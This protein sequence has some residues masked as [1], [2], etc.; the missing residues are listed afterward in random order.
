MKILMNHMKTIYIC[1]LE[2]TILPFTA[3]RV[4]NDTISIVGRNSIITSG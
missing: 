4:N 1:M 3:F 2:I